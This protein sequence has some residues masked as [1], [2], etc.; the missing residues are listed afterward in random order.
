MTIYLT[1]YDTVAGNGYLP[2][3]KKIVQAL[4]EVVINHPYEI[5][6]NNENV[7]KLYS[8]ERTEVPVF[9]HPIEIKV[10][11]ESKLFLDLRQYAKMD[12]STG[13]YSYKLTNESSFHINRGLLNAIWIE[14]DPQI[15][16]NISPIPM[17]VFSGWISENISRRFALDP[18]DQL[19]IA[20][21]AAYYYY[22]L[23]SDNDVFDEEDLHRI[24]SAIS[25]NL[26]CSSTDVISILDNTTGLITG[27]QDFCSQLENV[28]SNL[29]LRNFNQT[30]LFQLLGGSWFG[31]NARE[32][33]A[34]ALEHPPTW[35]ALVLAAFTERTYRNTI[36]AKTAE[37]KANKT[38]GENFSRAVFNLILK[39]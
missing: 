19:N 11:G 13:N 31:T 9:F 29:R 25:R 33:L 23:F 15:M 34:V 17:V 3:V 36:L 24:T 37:R 10:K 21:F 20:I 27:V 4:E 26:R 6:E 22:C 30:L 2:T 16:L 1:A 32:L 5:D 39:T 38:A 18:K 7:Y 14:K 8:H 12:R 28:T 35:I